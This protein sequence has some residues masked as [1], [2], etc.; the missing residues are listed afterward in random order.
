MNCDVGLSW[1]ACPK[2]GV[3]GEHFS[4]VS[5]PEDASKKRFQEYVKIENADRFQCLACKEEW[6]APKTA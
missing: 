1:K 5:L 2:C 4:F 6:K 3:S